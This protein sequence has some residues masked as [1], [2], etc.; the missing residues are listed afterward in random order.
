MTVPD[1]GPKL[2]ARE[3]G[4]LT[5]AAILSEVAAA[6][7]RGESVAVATVI[8]TSRSVPR[9]AGSKMLVRSDGTTIASVGGGEMESRVV[10]EAL[11]ALADGAIHKL[12]YDLVDTSKGDP[13][14]CGGTVEILIEPHLPS[15]TLYVIGCGHVGRAVSDLAKWLGFRV[16]ATD[17]RVDLATPELMPSADAV[18]AGPLDAA[19]AT[20]PI[21]R[22]TSVVMVTRNVAVDLELLPSIFATNARYIGLMGSARRWQTTRSKLAEAGATEADLARITTPIGLEIKAETPEEIA[23]SILAQVVADRRG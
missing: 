21:D 4:P 10:R 3:S 5:P 18:I 17:D 1:R 23:V 13:G 16:I 20:H 8:Q 2:T 6:N 11:D 22:H 15:P 7:A 12:T 9:R 14:V 19:L